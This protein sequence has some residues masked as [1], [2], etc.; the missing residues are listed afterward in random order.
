MCTFITVLE[1]LQGVWIT[2]LEAP[3]AQKTA[4]S[5]M[6]YDYQYQSQCQLCTICTNFVTNPHFIIA[7]F[8]P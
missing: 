3:I 2:A 7:N 5:K 8:F 6:S 4:P 1:R